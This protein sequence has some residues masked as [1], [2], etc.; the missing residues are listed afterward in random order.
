MLSIGAADQALSVEALEAPGGFMWWYADLVSPEGDGVV[1]IWAF[2][3][4]FLPGRESA[5][6]RGAG[7]P[8]RSQPSLAVSVYEGGRPAFYL[9]QEYDE[10]DA[11][12]D[13]VTGRCRLGESRFWSRVE[14]G[15]RVVT[16]ELDMPVPAS[17]RLTG[18][19]HLDGEALRNPRADLP[20]EGWHVWA[21]LATATPGHARLQLGDRLLTDVVGRAYHDCNGSVAP[22]S[23]LGI[24]EWA[25]GREAQGDHEDVHYV[26]WPDGGG[27]PEAHL[28]RL[29]ADG[30]VEVEAAEVIS[31]SRRYGTWGLPWHRELRLLGLDSGRERV[32]RP[33]AAIDDG[34]FYLRSLL[35]TGTAEWVRPG[36]VDLGFMRPFVDMCVHRPKGRNAMLLPFFTGERATR[37]RRLM[38]PERPALPVVV[39]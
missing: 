32:V 23:G 15:R 16:V 28:L 19:L 11:E 26:L 10:D 6:R 24:R 37:W 36:R 1:L 22:L 5:A 38:R 27:A 3:L 7:T 9:L 12:V 39:P 30:R 13:V 34:P 14:D 17:P 4:P 31:A 8:G 33:G 20:A 25:W 2:G 29:G 21:P 18:T 35:G